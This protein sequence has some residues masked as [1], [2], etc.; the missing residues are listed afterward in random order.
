MLTSQTGKNCGD[1][2]FIIKITNKSCFMYY[3]AIAIGLVNRYQVII[4]GTTDVPC[5]NY[6][7]AFK[8]VS[9]DLFISA[10]D[11]C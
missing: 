8:Q 4:N 10:F 9:L 11:F 6:M 7:L 1:F 5:Q 3:Q 2:D